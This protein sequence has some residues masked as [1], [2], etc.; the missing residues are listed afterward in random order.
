MFSKL[1]NKSSKEIAKSHQLALNLSPPSSNR[2]GKP[3]LE[4][5]VGVDWLA[6][7][8]SRDLWSE[9]W[10][11]ISRFYP[12]ELSVKSSVP[13]SGYREVTEF[14]DGP[15]VSYSES[16]PEIHIQFSGEVI[17]MLCLGRQVSL[18]RE[19]LG[20]GAKCTRIDLRFDD[21]RQLV[22]PS[23]MVEW[24][25]QGFLC[26]F[27]RWQPIQSFNNTQ[28][29]GLTFTAGRRGKLGS[30]CYFRCYEWHFNEV[31]KKVNGKNKR[32]NQ[33]DCIRFESAFSQHKAQSVCASL[34]EISGLEN[35]H[36]SICGIVLGSIDFRRG[37]S[38]QGYRDRSRV[39][40]WDS[41]T[42]GIPPYK[43]VSP[44]RV[45]TRDFP[46]T[47]FSRQW[48]GKLAA[49]LQSQGFAAFSQALIYS[50]T[51]GVRRGYGLAVSADKLV[52]LKRTLSRIYPNLEHTRR[53]YALLPRAV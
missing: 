44:K 17:G 22:T 52:A 7:T 10:E 40:V 14:Q 8:V 18:I 45:V 29:L 30:G 9:C 27:K 13:S 20:L 47:A 49:L 34:V 21:F 41:Y 33:T 23:Q 4:T 51:D 35:L 25:E 24:A 53:Q 39:P 48:G 2:G 42:I 28:S 38:E 19:F 1:N 43:F 37:S 6:Y 11:I 50:T 36:K 32:T 5:D 26:R 31:E 15:K 16:R 12:L 3:D 46:L